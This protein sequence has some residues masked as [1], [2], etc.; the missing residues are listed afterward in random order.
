MTAPTS[1]LLPTP[2]PIKVGERTL[3]FERPLIMGV[4]NVTPDSF[5]DGGLFDDRQRAIA[6]AHEMIAQ[7][8]DIIDVG[9]ESTRPGAPPVSRDEELRRVLPIIEALSSQTSTPISIDT[10]KSDVADAALEAGAAL[11]NDISGATLDPEILA[12]TA[13]HGAALVLMHMLG[14]PE[15]MQSIVSYGD[16]VRDVVDFLTRRVDAAV[17]AGVPA[18]R[19]LVDPGIGFGKHLEHNLALIR[20]VGQLAAL[21]HPVLL[22]TSRKS[23]LGELTGRTEPTRRVFGTAATVALGVEYGAHVFRV[24]DVAEMSDVVQVAHAVCRIGRGG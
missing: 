2:P 23:F 15:T 10:T 14:T 12:V 3:D 21:G 4:L 18:A 9:G 1:P 24:H 16:V 11:V 22:G 6:R 7:G 5:S 13:T 8:A 19:I 20:G 17:A